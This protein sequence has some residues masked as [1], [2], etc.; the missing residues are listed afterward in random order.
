MAFY[1][2]WPE[3]AKLFDQIVIEETSYGN[4]L[5][6]TRNKNIATNKNKNI[7]KSQ[8]ENFLN[9]INQEIDDTL[10]NELIETFQ[11][12]ELFD[13]DG[14]FIDSFSK[15]IRDK[16]PNYIKSALKEYFNIIENIVTSVGSGNYAGLNNDPPGPAGLFP[17]STKS[18]MMCRYGKRKG[19]KYLKYFDNE[20]EEVVKEIS[21]RMY[22]RK[23]VYLKDKSTGVYQRLDYI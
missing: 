4:T 19:E 6:E 1:E 12:Y 7:K 13:N 14:F 3:V 11:F 8:V 15:L 10:V 17:V 22:K 16:T 9:S 5:V 20:D 18:F 2:S 23:P 21:Q